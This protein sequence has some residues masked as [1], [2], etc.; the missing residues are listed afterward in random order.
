MLHPPSEVPSCTEL[1]HM[2]PLTRVALTQPCA[3]LRKCSGGTGARARQPERL[4]LSH[5][6]AISQ[7]AT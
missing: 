4:G 6:S 2:R 3:F 5:A 7:T 1:G